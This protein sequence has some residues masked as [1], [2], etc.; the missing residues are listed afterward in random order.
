MKS[1][2]CNLKGLSLKQIKIFFLKLRVRLGCVCYFSLFLKEK[3]IS[4]L[5][6]TK[7]IEKKFNFQLFF[8]PVIYH[9]LPTFLKRLVLKKELHVSSRQC[10]W[11][12][13]F[14]RWKNHVEEWTN[15]P[16]TYQGKHSERPS[17]L[18]KRFKKLSYHLSR[19]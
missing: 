18:F 10:S 7:Y 14:P 1:I 11:R 5:F 13:H 16:S 4:L 19:V 17:N 9:A 12:R 3:C 8:L 2:F 15:K 6:R